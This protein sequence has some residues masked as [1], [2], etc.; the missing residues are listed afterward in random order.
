M[1]E[2]GEATTVR[3]HFEDIIPDE[4]KSLMIG[5]KGNFTKTIQW[6]QRPLLTTKIYLEYMLGHF[7]PKGKHFLEDVWHGVCQ[8]DYNN[9]GMLGWYKHRLWIYTPK[10][11]IKR[12]YNLDGRGEEVKYEQYF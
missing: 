3:F 2:S 9:D 11:G 8:N 5:T 1:I 4:H 7:N 10:N 12:S 6:S